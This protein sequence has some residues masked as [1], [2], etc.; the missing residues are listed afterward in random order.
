M[1]DPVH[2][3]TGMDVLVP[4]AAERP[5][6]RL[7]AVLD[8]AERRAFAGAMLGDVLRAIR[9]AGH[10]SEV[11]ATAPVDLSAVADPPAVDDVPVTVD[12]VPVTV[13][14]VPVTVDERPLSPA[15]NDA[16]AARRPD[17]DDPL[18]VV[19]AD[20]ALATP[21]AIDRLAAAGGDVAIAPGR[22]GGTNA[23]VVRHPEFR[24]DYH[25][26]S[27]RDHRAAAARVGADVDVVDSFRLS[28]DVDEPADL[29]EVL[30]HGEGA[31]AD[32]LRDAGV[33]LAATSGRVEARRE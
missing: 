16:L 19:M 25:G 7:G 6:T 3:P 12:D 14:D 31:A 26:A 4:F 21:G 9:A 11:L 8:A 22:G 5:K 18:A 15:V 33:S 30:L 27:F 13:D 17:A 10:A 24:V 1:I 28:T 23:L 2:P 32:W 29:A 20:L